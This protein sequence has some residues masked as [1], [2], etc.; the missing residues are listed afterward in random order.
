MNTYKE[1]TLHITSGDW[2]DAVCEE[3]GLDKQVRDALRGRYEHLTTHQASLK[4]QED[5]DDEVA[6]HHVRT[7]LAENP[8]SIIKFREQGWDIKRRATKSLDI[9]A[10][11]ADHNVPTDALS[12]TKSKLPR[13]LK[14]EITK[15]ESTTGYTFIV[16]SRS[17][18]EDGDN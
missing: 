2:I 13:E 12:V 3:L 7:E 11:L 18:P 10:F 9:T 1:I 6:R 5:S 15:Y 8:Q 17:A 16:G 14:K 4:E